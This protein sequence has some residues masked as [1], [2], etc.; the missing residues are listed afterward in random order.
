MKEFGILSL[1]LLNSFLQVENCNESVC[2][3][4]VSKCLLIKSCNCDVHNSTCFGLCHTCLGKYSIEC[5]SCVDICPKHIEHIPDKESTVEDHLEPIPQ[6]FNILVEGRDPV[7]PW[8]TETYENYY[9]TSIGEL[10]STN[11]SIIWWDQC[12]S[13]Q[14]CKDQCISLGATSTRMFH[15]GCCECI[16]DT[17]INYGR[18]KSACKHC[19]FTGQSD[20]YPLSP[21]E[22]DFD[23]DY[24]EDSDF[25][26]TQ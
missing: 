9:T 12:T 6:L 20:E 22:N 18:S 17:C 2:A 16:G 15:N 23:L 10:V 14:K 5:C 7:M 4:V 1:L 25:D 11:C 19:P 21:D 13:F 26:E 8:T 3:P 24:G